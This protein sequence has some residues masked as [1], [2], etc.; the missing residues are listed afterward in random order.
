MASFMQNT[1]RPQTSANDSVRKKRDDLFGL[2]TDKNS[3]SK[4]DENPAQPNVFSQ[5]QEL[6]STNNLA[7]KTGNN[8]D[9]LLSPGIAQR[10]PQ[11]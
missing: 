10:V 5:T 3:A 4:E 8:D 11:Q 9:L 2:R 7:Q 6:G 1:K